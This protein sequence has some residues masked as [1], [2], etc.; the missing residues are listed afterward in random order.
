MFAHPLTPFEITKM[1]ASPEI[2]IRVR[3]SYE[4]MLD[5]YGMR[6]MD[7]ETGLVGRKDDGWED[8]YQ[9]L[10]RELPI[11]Y[12]SSSKLTLSS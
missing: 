10:M 6:L 12:G 2:L 4:L 5:F 1:K 3:R 8:R 7:T 9:N 11:A